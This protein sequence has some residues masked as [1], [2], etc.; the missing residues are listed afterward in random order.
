MYNLPCDGFYTKESRMSLNKVMLIGRLGK[1][2]ESKMTQTGKQACSFSLATSEVWLQ[3]GQKK[4]K[5]EWHKVVTWGKTAEIAAR[6]LKKGKEVYVEGKLTTRSW[7][8]PDG[9]KRYA[10]EVVA[11][12]IKFIGN[13]DTQ[14]S[15]PQ[16]PY[17]HNP[18]SQES[19][20]SDY[21]DVPF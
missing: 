8:G 16:A 21:D 18:G 2:P 13:K 3:D 10:T 19:Y 1:D 7:D 5:T 11:S 14:S 15:E 4:E 6:Y 12:E 9:Q 17:G 20:S